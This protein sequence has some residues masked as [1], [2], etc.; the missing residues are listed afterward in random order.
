MDFNQWAKL[1]ELLVSFL[2]I[3]IWPLVVMIV[4]FYLR[5][6]LKGFLDNLIE[7]SLKLGPIETTIKSKQ[8]IEVATSLGAATAHWQDAT[9]NSQEVPDTEKAKEIAKAIDYLITPRT[10]RQL[11][12]ASVLWV[13]DRPLNNTYERQALEALGIQFTISKSTEDA[14]E[15]LKKKRYNLIISDMERPPDQQAGYTLLEQVKAR[16]ITTPY[17]IYAGSKLPEHIAEAR[18]REAFGT[19]NDPKELLEFVVEALEHE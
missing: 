3:I 2:Q 8:L 6:P 12:Q 19:T 7:I 16:N 11:K 10:F 5:T 18:R 1:L 15:R 13:D 4:L 14:L 9:Q 17:I